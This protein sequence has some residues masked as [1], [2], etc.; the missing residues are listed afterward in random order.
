MNT[1]EDAKKVALIFKYLKAK[2]SPDS[3][4]RIVI[5]EINF[6]SST[7]PTDVTD[8]IFVGFDV[9]NIPLLFVDVHWLGNYEHVRWALR[10]NELTSSITLGISCGEET[11]NPPAVCL[12][13]GKCGMNFLRK[14]ILV[15]IYGYVAGHNV[16]DLVP[17]FNNLR[18][19]LYSE[20]INT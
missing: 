8:E 10:V 12:E 6:D 9:K 17:I 2:L 19:F 15:A 13:I 16:R 20:N 4:V 14:E 11:K 3:G 18:S 1:I 7:L 5:Q